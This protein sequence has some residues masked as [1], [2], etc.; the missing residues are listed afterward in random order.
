MRADRALV[1]LPGTT[2]P[3]L[4]APDEIAGSRR[5]RPGGLPD[6]EGS[7]RGAGPLG[8]GWLALRTRPVL[9][10]VGCALVALGVGF[11]LPTKPKDALA[12][13]VGAAVVVAVLLRPLFGAVLLV[14]A[15]PATSGFAP[16]FPV[17][18]VRLSEAV[19]GLVGVTLLVSVRRTETV[20]WETLDWALLGYGLTWAA[21]AVLA[22][23]QLH[24]HLTLGQWGT[25]L[26]QLQFFLIYRGVRVAVRSER[27]RQGALAA[28][29]V[30]SLPVAAL[31]VLQEAR[32]HAVQSFINTLTGGLTGGAAPTAA[33]SVRVTGPFVNW[34]ALAGY[35]LPIVLVVVAL[36][37]SKH[38]LRR[39]RWFAAVG[40]AGALAMVLTLEQSAIVCALA[41]VFVLLRR[42]DRNGRMTRLFLVGLAVLVVAASPVLI[43]RLSH[44]LA[45]TPGS[46]RVP[47]V[48]QTL[49][50]RWSVWTRQYFP[51]IGA[52]PLTGYGMVYPGSIS[53]PFPESQYIAFL[54]EGGVV[55]MAA[56]AALAWAML[57]RARS[58]VRFGDPL[59]RALGCALT[60]G[61][62]AMIVMDITW[63]FLSNG[64][65]PQV[66]WGLMALLM[67]ASRSAGTA[68]GALWHRR[69][70][71]DLQVPALAAPGG[72]GRE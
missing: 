49:S 58:A 55:M 28:L 67:P 45:G 11:L 3:V 47:W 10:A 71:F 60:I 43:G 51:A 5:D 35:L 48:P 18:H 68:T 22:Q 8:T 23:R 1:V 27:E 30:A 50:F 32:V 33:G 46:G 59:D 29:M 52:R 38:E 72:R 26:G 66:L 15:V 44:E 17:S 12:L 20:P 42:Y 14:A 2:A 7:S 24:Q 21:F 56:F 69:A 25:A 37:L 54:M 57:R 6:P 53:W 34:A 4:P 64:G 62:V 40:I 39:A 70:A 31:A 41:G 63:P 9:L 19:I 16:G 61:V 65:M 13:L 36:A